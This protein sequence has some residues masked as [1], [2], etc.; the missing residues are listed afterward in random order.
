MPKTSVQALI[1]ETFLDMAEALESGR[2]G[3][4]PKIAL[5][6]I[7]SEL[8]EENALKG[9]VLASKAGVDVTY[10][11]TLKHDAVTHV[12]AS[13]EDEAHQAMEKLLDEGTVAGAVTMHYP[14]PIG[15]ATVGR[16]VIPANGREMFLATTTGTAATDRVSGMVLGAIYGIIAAK[17]CGVDNP[18]VGILNIDGARQTEIALKKLIDGG[19]P[20]TLA[21]SG[22][23]DGGCIMRGNDM[24]T[25]SADVMVMDTLTGNLVI[26]MLSSFASGGTYE[27]LGYGYGPGIGEEY[28]RLV[29][30]VSRA[31]G[32]SVIA[33]ALQYAATLVQNDYQAVVKKEFELAKKAGL[34]ELLL[35]ITAAK[36][37]AAPENKVTAPPKEIV[38]CDIAGIDVMDLETAVEL[39]WENGIYAESGMGCTGPI[40]L[41]ADNNLDRAAEILRK[42]G[43]IG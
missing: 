40:V 17:A 8:G 34:N 5:T 3:G 39:L 35:E 31:S 25:G 14:F 38:T 15:V 30:I 7:G 33:G 1:K 19:Y 6:G 21:Q 29:M 37:A 43:F 28:D 26:K 12:P 4:R 11:G 23:A 22:R 2:M 36:K 9:A 13:N 18:T 10:I 41:I 32:T 42:G 27:A 20:I 24:L 16:A